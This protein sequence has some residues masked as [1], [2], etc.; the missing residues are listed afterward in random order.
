MALKKEKVRCWEQV[1]PQ[2]GDI[3]Y[4]SYPEGAMGHR[5][6]SCLNCGCIYSI[7]ITKELYTVPFSEKIQ[8]IQCEECGADLSSDIANYPEQFK[9]KNGS[10]Q[11]FSRNSDIPKDEDSVEK[12][13]FAVY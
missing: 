1:H 13:F 2:S 10:I 7:N 9:A 4:I 3:V 8:D 6:T 5:L 11:H 12:Y